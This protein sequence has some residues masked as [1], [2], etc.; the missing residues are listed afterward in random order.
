MSPSASSLPRA[1]YG[2]WKSPI[3]AKL[4]SEADLSVEDLLVDDITRNLYVLESRPSEGGRNAIVSATDNQ[5]IYGASWN[6]RSR[7]HEYGGAPALAYDGRV[8]FSN[9][10][11]GRVYEVDATKRSIPTAVTPENPSYR[12]GDFTLHPKDK[13]WLVSILE[14]HIVDNAT[15]IKTSLI[16]INTLTQEFKII[17]SGADFYSSPRFSPDGRFIVWKEWNFPY[18][19]IQASNLMLAPFSIPDDPDAFPSVGAAVLVSGGNGKINAEPTWTPAN[20]LVFTTDKDGYLNPWILRGVSGAAPKPEPLSCVVIQ[21]EFGEPSWF[22]GLSSFAMYDER[23]V[24]FSSFRSGRSQLHLA[25]LDTGVFLPVETPF[26]LI[27]HVRNLGDGKVVFVGKKADDNFGVIEFSW[28]EQDHKPVYRVLR[29]KTD[30]PFPKELIS[31]PEPVELQVLPEARTTHVILYLPKNPD[32]LGGLLGELPPAIFNLHGGPNSMLDQALDWTK[33]YYSSRGWAW[34]DLNYNG[35][36]GYG[37]DYMDRL[38][39][40]WGVVDVRDSVE[41]LRELGKRGLIDVKRSAIRGR[42][43][44]GFTTLQT[45]STTTDSFQAGTA[46]FPASDL[47]ALHVNCHKFQSQ[48]IPGLVGAPL[49]EDS[50]LW[51]KRSPFYQANQIKAPVLIMQGAIDRIVPPKQTRD[52]AKTIEAN[53]GLVKYIEFEGEGHGWRKADSIRRSTEEELA[54]YQER[55]GLTEAP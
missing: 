48:H 55:F 51:K 46:W 13:K 16:A 3:N 49:E 47:I 20:E 35:S 39:G 12:Y 33:Q 36:T 42:S 50:A 11:D 41:A 53:G 40:Q 17:V 18:M 21:E 44:G 32:Y 19:P 27:Q 23:R 52:M 34:I 37:R 15:G 24:L 7:I 30:L 22:L 5:D 43:G 2:T 4:I 31:L 28:S 6:A 14:D 45:L 54:F 26:V 8:Y 25:N 10:M 29:E 1:P 9:I 38:Q